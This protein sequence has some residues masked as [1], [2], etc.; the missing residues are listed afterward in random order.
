MNIIQIFGT[1]FI[2]IPITAIAVYFMVGG[3]SA[4]FFVDNLHGQVIGVCV[5]DW[6]A[7]TLTNKIA[8][9]CWEITRQLF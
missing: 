7:M 2:I 6:D 3:S 5:N 4:P 1:F 9:H 8:K